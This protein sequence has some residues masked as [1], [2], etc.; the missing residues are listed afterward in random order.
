MVYPTNPLYYGV[1]SS[2]YPPVSATSE[3]SGDTGIYYE[4]GSPAGGTWLLNCSSSV[5][6]VSYTWINGTVHMFNVTKSSTDLSALLSSS[7]AYSNGYL[8]N[9]LDTLANIAGSENNSRA[10]A[11]SFAN[12][13]S[14]YLLA[15]SVG[16]M[17]P[18]LNDYEPLRQSGIIVAR[19]PLIPLYLLLATKFIY[20]IAFVVLAI[21]AYCFT[22][23]AET[24]IVKA[25][26]SVNGLAA[27]HF[28]QPSLVQQN[29]VKELE[30]RLDLA[31][32]KSK[33]SQPVGG[34]ENDRITHLKGAITAPVQGTVGQHQKAKVGLLPGAD[35]TRQFVVLANGVWNSIR[36]I[37]E[38]LVVTDA[39]KGGLGEAGMFI[40]AWK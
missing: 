14:S 4:V 35:G 29:V 12:G 1:W 7:F 33:T 21:G 31:K 2:G 13:F 39:A 27:A 9:G 3:Y 10:I 20:V 24:E 8:Q 34:S 22:Q 40:N 19:I 26:L 37:V 38:N 16:A 30:R 18:V 17:G 32:D 6:D 36:P 5:F 23:P 11:T 25:Q 28:N 15:Y